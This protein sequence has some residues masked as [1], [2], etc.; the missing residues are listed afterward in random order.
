M[1]IFQM[2]F[3]MLLR[4]YDVRYPNPFLSQQTLPTSFPHPILCP[5]KL[6]VALNASHRPTQPSTVPRHLSHWPGD[7]ST[8]R[9]EAP[10]IECQSLDLHLGFFWG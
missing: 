4:D 10:R 6:L 9:L 8:C 3:M 1:I 5:P 2:T 7:R